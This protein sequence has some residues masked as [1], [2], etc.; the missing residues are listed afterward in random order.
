[1]AAIRPIFALEPR[2][3]ISPAMPGEVSFSDLPALYS[4][5]EAGD[6]E[7]AVRWHQPGAGP[8]PQALAAALGARD[9][10]GHPAEQAVAMPVSRG[11]DAG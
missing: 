11:P 2:L 5:I 8:G 7:L 4:A 9:A 6:A 3:H 10:A 1:M